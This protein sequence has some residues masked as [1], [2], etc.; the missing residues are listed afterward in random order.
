MKITQKQFCYKSQLDAQHLN[1]CPL[2]FNTQTRWF[3]IPQ[4]IQ[5]LN[6]FSDMCN[7]ISYARLVACIVVELFVKVTVTWGDTIFLARESIIFYKNVPPS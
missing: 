2:T 5:Y 3:A 7:F 6:K 4:N 1:L